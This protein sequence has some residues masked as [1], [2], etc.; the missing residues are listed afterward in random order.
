MKVKQAKEVELRPI[1]FIYSISM[2]QDI[3]SD[4]VKMLSNKLNKMSSELGLKDM[5]DIAKYIKNNG[6]KMAINKDILRLVDIGTDQKQA[7]GLVRLY[8]QYLNFF[9]RNIF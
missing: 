9:K 6:G 8:D 3:N 2:Y 4:E 1:V 5:E 7:K